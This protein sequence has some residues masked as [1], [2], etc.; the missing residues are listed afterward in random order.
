M[1]RNRLVWI[2]ATAGLIAG[3]LLQGCGAQKAKAPEETQEE[4]ESKEKQKKEKK[5]EKKEETEASETAATETEEEERRSGS[6]YLLKTDNS[7]L[8]YVVNDHGKKQE[9]FDLSVIREVV[10]DA[11]FGCNASGLIGYENGKLYFHDWGSMPDDPTEG[12]YVV[13]AI[14]PE[15]CKSELLWIAEASSGDFVCAYELYQ[16]SLYLTVNE[17]GEDHELVYTL[18][19]D[20]HECTPS[21]YDELISDTF[22]KNR[23]VYLRGNDYA[24]DS[25]SRILDEVGFLVTY[26]R[27][28]ELYYRVFPD[29]AEERIYGLPDGNYIQPVDYDADGI[30]YEYDPY[31]AEETA[32]GLY[33]YSFRNERTELQQEYDLYDDDVFVLGRSDD[34]IYMEWNVGDEYG[35]PI[36]EI[37]TRSLKDWDLNTI[38]VL[39]DV[40][41]SH[42]GYATASMQT[43]FELIGEDVYIAAV[44]DGESA[45]VRPS[46]EN[47]KTDLKKINCPI[48][49]LSTLV[50]G[51]V[52]YESVTEKCP[53][54]GIPLYMY[55]EECFQLKNQYSPYADA[56]NDQLKETFEETLERRAAESEGREYT[57]EDC[58]YHLEYTTQYQESFEGSISSVE[59]VKDKYLLVNKTGYWYGGGAHGQPYRFQYAFNLET[60][61]RFLITDIFGG[62]NEEFKEFCAEATKEDLSNY[63][64]YTCP[65]YQYDPDVVYQQAYDSVSLDYSTIEFRADGA[66][67]IYEP[68]EMGPF[69][70]GFIEVKLF[71]DSIYY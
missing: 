31:D 34:L 39:E 59:I 13:Y 14:D 2:L 25:Y 67:L 43:P 51:D 47:G 71:D 19:G 11:T 24:N 68:Y 35:H 63:T 12:A 21:S 45:W 27:D 44:V 26:D 29:G 56:I 57:D 1:K 9:T 28:S 5:E 41:G 48:E 52:T 15:S 4:T 46:Y 58:E 23:R 6:G 36:K 3:L 18:S 8:V 60:G 55:Y 22:A 30:V 61:G 38:C 16:G 40:P 70:S 50:Y 20:H 62:D 7:D 69:A 10:D 42:G 66:Y 37:Y 64:E 53:Y 33:Y 32:S 65:Y 17:D 54:C 49:T